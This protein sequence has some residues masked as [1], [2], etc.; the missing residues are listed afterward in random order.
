MLIVPT[1]AS[2]GSF[3]DSHKTDR[4]ANDQSKNLFRDIEPAFVFY[5]AMLKL[6]LVWMDSGGGKTGTTSVMDLLKLVSF[7]RA[8]VT[9]K[10]SAYPNSC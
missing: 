5:K 3:I 10:S 1:S 8:L 2:K 6:R 9:L 4:R 7:L